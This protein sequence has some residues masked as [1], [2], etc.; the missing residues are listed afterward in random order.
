MNSQV[1]ELIESLHASER[2]VS[3]RLVA[4]EVQREINFNEVV[5]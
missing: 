3:G 4:D 1:R 5:S 2:M